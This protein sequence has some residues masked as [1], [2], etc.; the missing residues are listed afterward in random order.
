LS[1]L[2]RLLGPL[3]VS[4]G[5]YALP[6]GEGR[7]RAVL[8]LLLLH[9]NKA[10]SSDRLIDALWG[11]TPPPTAAKVLQNHIGQLRRALDDREGQRLQTRDHGYVLEVQD[12]ELDVE[13]FERLVDEGAEAPA[14]GRPADAAARLREA[15][16][17]WRGPA[18][19][20]VAPSGRSSSADGPVRRHSSDTAGL[21]ARTSILAARPDGPSD[22]VS[23]QNQGNSSLMPLRGAD[24]QGLGPSPSW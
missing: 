12:G 13:R 1:V 22:Q 2:F 14:R 20:D 9:R 5:D 6:I 23:N 7:Q 15:L 10:V 4:D 3:E 8:V 11:E 16:A 19:A 18:L 17:F 24:L 21:T